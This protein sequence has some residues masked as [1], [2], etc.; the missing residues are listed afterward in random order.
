VNQTAT[1]VATLTKA[2]V[3]YWRWLMLQYGPTRS[4]ICMKRADGDCINGVPDHDQIL[5]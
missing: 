3:L 4:A 5:T 2:I 1:A